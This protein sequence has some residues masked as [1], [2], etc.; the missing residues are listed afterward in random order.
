MDMVTVFCTVDDFASNL[1]PLGNSTGYRSQ[2]D[3]AAVLA[4]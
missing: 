4:G 3:N 2:A 1:P